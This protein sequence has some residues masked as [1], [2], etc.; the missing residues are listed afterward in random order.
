[1]HLENRNTSKAL[2]SP[3]LRRQQRFD[4]L[5]IKQKFRLTMNV[6]DVHNWYQKEVGSVVL[7]LLSLRE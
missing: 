1:M 7:S 5:S 3:E 4:R 2:H 6:Y